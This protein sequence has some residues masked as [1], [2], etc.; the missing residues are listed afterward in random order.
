MNNADWGN[1]A[2][3]RRQQIK[4]TYVQLDYKKL[5]WTIVGAIITA[6]VIMSLV[7]FIFMSLLTG[8]FI[9][10]L[11]SSFNGIAEKHTLRFQTP[12]V[13][14]QYTELKRPPITE[15]ITLLSRD[16]ANVRRINTQ[17]CQFWRDQYKKDNLE[18]SKRYRDNA[19]LR[20]A[21]P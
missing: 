4:T 14:Q 10:S 18:R 1:N 21:Q 20:V 17:T 7:G 2:P 5:F 3:E 9:K 13:A 19:C 16:D 6:S 12:A 11:N 15:K 8:A